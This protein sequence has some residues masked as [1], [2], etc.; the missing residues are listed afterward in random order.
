ML[1]YNREAPKM[2]LFPNLLPW[3]GHLQH[4]QVPLLYCVGF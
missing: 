1:C 3:L 4:F 2:L